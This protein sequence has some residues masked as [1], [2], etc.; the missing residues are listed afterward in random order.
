VRMAD[1]PSV[2]VTALVEASPEAVWELISDVTRLSEWGGECRGAEWV[3]GSGPGAG[4]RFRGLQRRGDMEWETISVVTKF[5]PGR[6]FAWAVNDLDNPAATWGFEL[7][8]EGSATRVAYAAVMGPGP[9]GLTAHI[10]QHP[11]REEAIVAAR[12][13]EHRRNM[14]TTL[15]AIKAV[16]EATR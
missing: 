14:T 7:S 2:E 12:L 1:R 8:P 10:D 6:T 16:A 11:D 13:E 15:A 3:E 5:E 9:S 4:G